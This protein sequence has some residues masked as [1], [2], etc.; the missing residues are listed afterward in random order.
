[1][2][3]KIIIGIGVGILLFDRIGL[4]MEAKGWI[5]WR[6]KKSSGGGL[7]NAFQ[8]MNAFLKPGTRHIIEIKKSDSKQSD[9]KKDDEGKV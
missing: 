4:W 5:Y 8:E 3:L 6:K 9:N 7:G 2:D 1:M